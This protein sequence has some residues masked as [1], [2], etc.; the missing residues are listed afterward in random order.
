MILSESLPIE[1]SNVGHILKIHNQQQI[2]VLIS[3]SCSNREIGTENK[4]DRNTC[5]NT[6]KSAKT[7]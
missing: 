7:Q 2:Q 5:Q 4:V 6:A 1:R 3:L